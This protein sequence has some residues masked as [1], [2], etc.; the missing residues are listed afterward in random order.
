MART[1]GEMATDSHLLTIPMIYPLTLFLRDSDD[2]S[3][4]SSC[5]STPEKVEN[6]ILNWI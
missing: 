1:L 5:V 3:L 4:Q 2:L 6:K